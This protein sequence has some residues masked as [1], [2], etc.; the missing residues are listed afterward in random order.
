MGRCIINSILNKRLKKRVMQPNEKFNTE[1]DIFLS[2]NASYTAKRKFSSG[3]NI[4]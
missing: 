1:K 2:N 3:F 4:T